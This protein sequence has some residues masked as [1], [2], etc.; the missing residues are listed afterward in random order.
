MG[1][2][3][4]AVSRRKHLSGEKILCCNIMWILKVS[5]P[6]KTTR[7]VKTRKTLRRTL[8]LSL[9]KIS[10]RVKKHN[11]QD[12]R[13]IKAEETEFGGKR[14][15]DGFYFFIGPCIL[16]GQPE[17]SFQNH[18]AFQENRNAN[19]TSKE[20]CVCVFLWPRFTRCKLN[21]SAVKGVCVCVSVCAYMQAFIYLFLFMA[22]VLQIGGLF[23]ASHWSRCFN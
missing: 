13:K 18:T 9:G 2:E 3:L 17:L 1:F 6:A 8:S 14:H 7:G 21:Y 20:V 16:L 11:K 19:D 5:V 23:C 22:W 15:K 12:F 4:N 10:N